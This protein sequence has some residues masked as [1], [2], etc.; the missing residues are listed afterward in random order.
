MRLLIALLLL[1]AAPAWGAIATIPV[2]GGGATVTGASGGISAA[3]FNVSAGDIVV[4]V[5]R[6]GATDTSTGVVLTAACGSEALTKAGA[7]SNGTT[8]LVLF[9]RINSGGGTACGG[10]VTLSGSTTYRSN[11]YLVRGALTA[12]PFDPNPLNASGGSFASASTATTSTFTQAFTDELVLGIVSTDSAPATI[13]PGSGETEAFAEY[14]NRLQVQ[15]LSSA[16]GGPRTMSWTFATATA[17]N[18]FLFGVKSATSSSAATPT[19]SVAPALG[20]RTT[21]TIP[22]TATT[23]CT[24]CTFYGVAYTDGLATPSCTQIKAGNDSSG[25]AAYKAFS[26][27]MTTTVQATGTF[28]TYTNGT[29]RDSAYCMNSTAGADSAVVAIADLYKIPAFTA[30]PTFSSCS[31]TGCSYTLTLDGPGTVYG[32]ACKADSTAA[33]VTQVEA[34][35][36]TGAVAAVASANKAVTGADTLTIGS[37]LDYPIH[38]FAIVGTY[39]SQHEAAIHADN[40]RTKTAPTATSYQALTSVDSQSWY[41]GITSPSVVATDIGEITNPTDILGQTVTALA[42]GNWNFANTGARDR[43]CARVY[44]RSVKDWMTITD[45]SPSCTGTRAAIWFNNQPPNVPAPGSIAF[46]VPL[47]SPMVPRDLSLY[48]PDPEGD[49][50]TVTGTSLPTGLAI[51]GNIYQGT[52]TV[53]GR[54]ISVFTCRDVAGD[55]SDW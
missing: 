14:N 11:V 31:I 47:N 40:A 7:I 50:V 13:A 26:Q 22:V 6:L 10:T 5:L 29:I 39:G 23:A 32:V 41:A 1:I 44:D 19:F 4:H 8:T 12:T 43:I 30:G 46:F 51:I 37:A 20:T 36:C 38:D 55:T 2:E 54:Y 45:P 28:S 42:D 21:S 34:G 53:R 15:Y 52:A 17:G 18:Y 24:D 9:Y 48:C 35:Q 25:S 49:T 3:N 16:T 33:T 27:A